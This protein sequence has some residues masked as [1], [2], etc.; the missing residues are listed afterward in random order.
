V[1]LIIATC[2]TVQGEAYHR[3]VRYGTG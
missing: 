1:K 3:N 2:G